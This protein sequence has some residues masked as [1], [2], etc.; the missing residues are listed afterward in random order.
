[1]MLQINAISFK[2]ILGC[3]LLV[4]NELMNII[5]EVINNVLM[6]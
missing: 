4:I 2:L 5:N 1:M 3:D 6:Q